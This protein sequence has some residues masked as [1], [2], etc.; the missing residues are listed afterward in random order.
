MTE[1]TLNHISYL[2][3]SR[4]TAYLPDDVRID[5]VLSE[6]QPTVDGDEYVRT[7]VVLE[8]RAPGAGPARPQ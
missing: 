7:T 4:L 8:E 6:Y 5:R 1:S 2:V 3:Y